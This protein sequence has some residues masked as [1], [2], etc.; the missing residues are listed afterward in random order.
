[1]Q[2]SAGSGHS[3]FI[4][5]AGAAWACGDH[6]HGKLGLGKLSADV[7]A[8]RKLKLPAGAKAAQASA[9]SPHPSL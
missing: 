9:T 1:M 3:V 4:T 2:A 5:D 8:P 6:S 7:L